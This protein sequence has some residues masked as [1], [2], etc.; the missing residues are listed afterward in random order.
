ML[1]YIDRFSSNQAMKIPGVTA[2][3]DNGWKSC[4]FGTSEREKPE[5]DGSVGKESRNIHLE[6]LT[7]A[8]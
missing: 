6:S 5:S 1:W 7:C 2:A 8:T 4:Q 3:V